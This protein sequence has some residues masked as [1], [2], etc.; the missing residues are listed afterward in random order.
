MPT[1]RSARAAAREHMSPDSGGDSA[2]FTDNAGCV[3]CAWCAASP[4]YRHYHDHEWGF[5]VADDRRLFEKLCLEGF[6]AGLS[7]L[8][9]LNKR[10][11]FRAA[12]ANF[13]AEALA[14]FGETEVRALLTNAAIVRHRGK[15]EAAIGNA[16]RA[17]E[18]RAEFGTLAC[19]IWG[20][21]PLAQQGRPAR[22]TGAVVRGLTESAVSRALSKDLKRRGWR[23]V[24]PTT[25]YA[26][27]QSMGVVND[28][29]EGCHARAAA[30]AA[31]AAFVPPG[32]GVQK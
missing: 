2:L 18:L 24:G 12:M 22:L 16:Q 3:R 25:M 4:L 10:E 23:F 21:A 13:E 29:I 19:Y 6:Q 8:T 1:T 20:F 14:R 15:I 32:G 11:A 17:L 26:F 28:H 9:I 27:L 30:A 31:R 5:P 7:W